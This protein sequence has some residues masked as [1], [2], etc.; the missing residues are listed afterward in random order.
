MKIELEDTLDW[1]IQRQSVQLSDGREL[2]GKFALVR[3]DN[4]AILSMCSNL[5]VPFTNNDLHVLVDRLADKTGYTPAGFQVMQRG[6]K[7]LAYLKTPDYT[8]CGQQ[9]HDY[10]IV[11]NSHDGRNR[12]FIGVTNFI[13][14]C[15]NQFTSN[16]HPTRWKHDRLLRIEACDLDE[17]F[18]LFL[19]ERTR[20]DEQFEY[21]RSLKVSKRDVHDLANMLF[22]GLLGRTQQPQDAADHRVPDNFFSAVYK[23]L[24]ELGF[25]GWALFNGVTRYTSQVLREKGKQQ[26]SRNQATWMNDYAFKYCTTSRDG[27]LI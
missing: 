26:V 23:E 22:S 20:R 9:V 10:L 25:T 5:Y 17:L 1:D 7:I 21:S 24:D 11:G 15:S 4:Q 14:R 13:Y 8:L 12:L 3:S 6:K 27:I 16:L 19:A 18:Y 2:P